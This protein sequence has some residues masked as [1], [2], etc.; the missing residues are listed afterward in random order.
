LGRWF[1]LETALAIA[2]VAS[3][4]RGVRLRLEPGVRRLVYGDLSRE[5]R[6]LLWRVASRRLRRQLMWI[7]APT[8]RGRG[9]SAFGRGRNTG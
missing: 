7:D 5:L 3:R 6:D 9:L 4:G 8:W 2:L 1:R